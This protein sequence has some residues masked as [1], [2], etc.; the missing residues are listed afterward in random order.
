[1][2]KSTKVSKA[3]KEFIDPPSTKLQDWNWRPLE[4]VSKDLNL[5][6]IP[7]YIQKGYGSFMADQAARAAA[8]DLTSRDLLKAYLITQSSIGRQGR[9]YNT[10]TKAGLKVPRTDELVRPEGAFAAWLGSKSGQRYLDAAMKGELD[11]KAVAEIQSQFAPFGKQNV[12]GKAMVGAVDMVPKMA[13]TLNQSIMGL[14]DDYRD[15]AEQLKGI[16]AAKSGFVGSLLGRGDLPTFDAR[17]IYLHTAGQPLPTKI[18][19]SI[20][21]RGKGLGGR[22]AVD[23]LAARQ[24]ALGLKLDPAL[25]PYYQHLAHHAVWDKSG[26]SQTT[27]QDLIDAMTN[28]KDGGK[29]KRRDIDEFKLLGEDEAARARPFD[30][31]YRKPEPKQTPM[32]KL[33]AILK[34]QGSFAAPRSRA[35]TMSASELA[36]RQKME[37]EAAAKK[38]YDPQDS[39]QLA[40][41]IAVGGIGG[42]LGYLAQI[43]LGIPDLA[44][45]VLPDSITENKYY[46]STENA[47]KMTGN[48]A[49]GIPS[50][51]PYANTLEAGM[52]AG[53][54]AAIPQAIKAAPEMVKAVGRGAKAVG[55]EV[56]RRIDDAMLTGEGLLGKALSPAR[57]SF[58]KAY[59][60]SPHR[61]APTEKN[62]LGEFDPTKIG[63]G[64][65]N[66]AYG[67]GHYLAEAPGTA[68][69]YQEA[70]AHK[71]FDLQR[72][73]ENLGLNLPVETRGRF[74]QQVQAKKPPEVLA[75]HFQNANIAA[76][77]LP[78][79]KL[80]ELIKLYQEKSKGNLY[81]VDL[82]D[83][84]IARM[85][86]WDKP[87]S[88][89]GNLQIKPVAKNYNGTFG[90]GEYG[91][92]AWHLGDAQL[93]QA[94]RT[95]EK[96]QQY[97][98]LGREI[99]KELN[100][101]TATPT[102]HSE[103]LSK[104]G[105]P[106]IQYL[107]A[108]SRGAG[109]GT[110]NFVVFPGGEDL[111][112]IEERMKKGGPVSQDAMQIK[113]WDKAIGGQVK[114][115][116]TGDWVKGAQKIV[117]P[118]AQLASKVYDAI[119]G[120]KVSL[121]P[122]A[123][124][125]I[126]LPGRGREKG[127]PLFPWLSTVDPNYE[128]IV[129]ANKG[130]SA[131]SKMINAAADNPG[132]IWTPQI[133]A[134]EMHR[135]NQVTYE[136]ILR[137]FERAQKKG[138][139]TPE[140]RDAYNDRLKTF[141]TDD[142][143]NPLFGKDF[144][145]AKTNLRK[146]ADTFPHRA[147]IAEVLGGV[148]TR[149]YGFKNRE[150]AQIIPYSK[151]IQ[152]TTEPELLNAPTGSLGP[153]MFQLTGERDVRPDLH[154]AFP[155]VV[156]GVDLGFHYAP[157]P[158]ELVFQDFI[159]Q[160]QNAKG[161]DPGHMDWDRNRVIQQVTPEIVQRLQDA[162]YK[163]G[164]A[165]N[166][167]EG[168]HSRQ[169][170]DHSLPDLGA[171][172]RLRMEDY[173][174]RMRFTGGGSGD[175]YGTGVGG[176]AMMNFPVGPAVVQP[177]VGGGV[178]KPQGGKLTGGV[179]EAGVN[180]VIP[181]ADG[182]EV[183]ADDLIVEER[184]L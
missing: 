129:W 26:N 16:A 97:A 25:D 95:P 66:Q 79:E 70:L 124:R 8:G 101:I 83:E 63:T 127:G 146:E 149:E 53:Q 1:M 88:P 23:R 114:H 134:P 21:D 69:G 137:A 122:A 17:Q 160:I 12:L 121:T 35:T 117:K 153:R 55:K 154:A 14:P 33:D 5:T 59:H 159:K 150:A 49:R 166:M 141:Y 168:G 58:I 161:R 131:T 18:P 109:E 163:D 40:R 39:K 138:E 108:G 22:E 19:E 100:A 93:S 86:D 133:G 140:L 44:S 41:D 52:T 92:Y 136:K 7:D 67:Y 184:P 130:R 78:Q 135:S 143:G 81:K 6:E 68:K 91:G 125:M 172:E 31:G 96:A 182:G 173:L 89:M 43:P 4:A 174:R 38:L 85:L 34:Q 164:G 156:S 10:A 103:L 123:D 169:P 104:A 72:E 148:G 155:E 37:E 106:G 90:T 51:E 60:G 128:G 165:V 27:H 47:I 76:R 50:L 158:R 36:L 20:L 139:L 57:P 107:D 180:L 9:S 178:Y 46:P 176:R 179:S 116:A 110:R 62:P 177:Y 71:G 48:I 142:N 111:L 99:I 167:A 2:A 84:H 30:T 115:M 11:K 61:F 145:I 170:V 64:E 45:M 112:T 56:G 132:L 73:S 175:K 119:L 42:G 157:T 120:E 65:G 87:L 80:T 118:T 32:E 74:F 147:A 171:E 24:D 75:K 13:P 113:A 144:D 183:S 82:P 3:V 94:F 54:Y 15:Y 151:I 105:I 29:V 126:A 28:Y 181:F 152:S 98:P 102:G 77:D 162:G